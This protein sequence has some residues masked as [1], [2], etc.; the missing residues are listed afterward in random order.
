MALP[1]S[2]AQDLCPKPARKCHENTMIWQKIAT[3][4][5]LRHQETWL[6]SSTFHCQSHPAW[7][8]MRSLLP[9]IHKTFLTLMPTLVKTRSFQRCSEN[10][11]IFNW[12]FYSELWS[13]SSHGIVQG[14]SSKQGTTFAASEPLFSNQTSVGTPQRFSTCN[15]RLLWQPERASNIITNQ[16]K[17]LTSTNPKLQWFWKW[18]TKKGINICSSAF[19]CAF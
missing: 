16:S 5:A 8:L 2:S 15:L 17:H 4:T 6:C 1:V 14:M 19:F 18:I 9:A 11:S 13:P 3:Q 7:R 10:V 12:C